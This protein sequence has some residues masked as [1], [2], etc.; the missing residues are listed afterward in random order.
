ML[1]EHSTKKVLCMEIAPGDSLIS[2]H[3]ALVQMWAAAA[4]QTVEQYT[5]TATNNFMAEMAKLQLRFDPNDGATV[6]RALFDIHTDQIFVDSLFNSDPHAG[7]LFIDMKHS[8][9]L[10]RYLT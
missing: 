10:G 2:V 4:G 9:R 3:P 6:L 7:N 8:C 5:G 1:E